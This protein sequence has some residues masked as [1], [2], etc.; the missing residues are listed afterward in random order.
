[1]TTQNEPVIT[2]TATHQPFESIQ[3]ALA[4]TEGLTVSGTGGGIS[5]KVNMTFTNTGCHFEGAINN[6]PLIPSDDPKPFS[7]SLFWSWWA[8]H[9]QS[10]VE[11]TVGKP[12]ARD[13]EKFLLIWIK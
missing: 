6:I 9:A 13:V 2:I 11:K 1:M 5:I 4:T 3:V 12:A 8:S 7:P 10:I